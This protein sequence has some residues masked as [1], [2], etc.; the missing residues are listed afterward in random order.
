MLEP[1]FL[2]RKQSYGGTVV[3]RA[4]SMQEACGSST[5]NRGLGHW[6]LQQKRLQTLDRYLIF[7]KKRQNYVKYALWKAKIM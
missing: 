4:T 7:A 5:T 6:I 1:V 3:E 2:K